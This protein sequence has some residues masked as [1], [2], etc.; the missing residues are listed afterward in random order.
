V[1][2]KHAVDGEVHSR[3]IQKLPRFYKTRHETSRGHRRFGEWEA[4]EFEYVSG[5]SSK[6]RDEGEQAME[7]QG[8]P[9]C[10]VE[11]GSGQGWLAEPPPTVSSK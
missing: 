6:G 3:D 9:G 5:W 2:P 11:F 7:F 1:L 4:E 10:K 8:L